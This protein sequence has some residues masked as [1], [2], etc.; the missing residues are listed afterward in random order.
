MKKKLNLLDSSFSHSV[1]G[2]CSD[3][4]KSEL[5]EWDR[6]L[7]KPI[8]SLVVTDNYLSHNFP[9]CDSL[10]AWLLEPMCINPSSYEFIKNNNHNFNKIFTHEKTLLDLGENY[11]LVPFGCCWVDPGQQNVYKKTKNISV[12]SSDKKQTDG[13]KLRH[14]VIDK[15]KDKM[16]VYGRGYSPIDRKIT[17]L[18]DYRFSIVIENCKKDYWFTE[19]LID[20]FV[21]GTIP[22]YWGC[23]SIGDFFDINGIITFNNLDELGEILN[24]CNENFYQSKIE[25]IKINFEKSKKY[26]LPDDCI[27]KSINN[28]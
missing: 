15:H 23:P 20:C 7:N 13:H 10:Y 18:K 9:K 1:L 11:E 21:T 12:I 14:L 26:F 6:D 22:I 2:Y 3:F 17:G 19:K 24:Q 5:F 16:D 27:Y 4:Q 8:E 28:L 25:S